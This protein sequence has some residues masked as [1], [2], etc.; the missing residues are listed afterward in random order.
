MLRWAAHIYVTKDAGR[1]MNEEHTDVSHGV[2]TAWDFLVKFLWKNGFHNINS[3]LSVS[4]CLV[5]KACVQTY[6]KTKSH[7]QSQY[8]TAPP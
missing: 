5:S 6:D 8:H 1:L 3:Y 7:I 2:E 4:A